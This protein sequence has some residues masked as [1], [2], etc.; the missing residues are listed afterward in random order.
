[1]PPWIYK[2]LKV[3][4][5]DHDSTI[6]EIILDGQIVLVSENSCEHLMENLSPLVFSFGDF[7]L[8]ISPGGYLYSYPI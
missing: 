6:H 5:N 4:L 8:E 2:N 3:Y 7:D 1:M